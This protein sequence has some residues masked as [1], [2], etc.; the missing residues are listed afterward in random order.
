M[1]KIAY[2][3]CGCGISGDMTLGALI[4]IGVGLDKLQNALGSLGI[5]GLALKAVEVK[6]RGF[7]AVRVTVD[8]DRQTE[9]RDLRQIQALIE[10]SNLTDRQ[11]E[12][13]LRIFNLL[14]KAESR[15]HGIPIEKVHFHEVGAVD[16]IA[17]VV[18][19]AVGWDLLGVDRAAASH[20]PTGS[21]KIRITHGECSIPAPA[22]AELLHGVPLAESSI[23]HELTTPTGAAILVALT[24]SFGPVPAMKIKRIG[25]GAGMRDFPQQP[26]ILRLL[27]GEAVEESEPDAEDVCVIE[28]NLDD[29]RGEIVAHCILRLWEAGALDVYTTPIGM[30]KDRP[31][32]K[33]TV[34]C[35]P[36]IAA[37]IE[38]V[39]FAETTTLGVRRWSAAR[40]SLRREPRTVETPWGPIEGVIGWR[41]DGAPRFSPEYEACRR[42]AEEH[43]VALRDV[44][45]A[46]ERAFEREER[47]E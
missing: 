5:P 45:S 47:I 25:Y 4:D 31:A 34:V 40:S 36:G 41:R 7:R 29:E 20:V 30:K 11:K 44:Y 8:A 9:H 6:R 28:T 12:L 15:V 14:G 23:R 33:L 35:R 46:A 10:A 43:G 17:D 24:D 13:A 2:L 19:T 16:S 38:D 39:L 26:N 3:D 21:G 32:V 27:V 42:V 37:L 22:T 18:G 1:T